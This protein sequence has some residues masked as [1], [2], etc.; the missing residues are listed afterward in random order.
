MSNP[1]QKNPGAG[2]TV[3]T[4]ASGIPVADKQ[5]SVTAGP[6][7]P[8]LLQDFHLI[9]LDRLASNIAAA[10]KDVGDDIKNVQI[11]HF[12]KTDPAYG[13]AVARKLAALGA[14]DAEKARPLS[15][16]KES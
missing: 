2:A 1:P 7:G 6:R 9:A 8:I 3:L 13:A 4:T 5:N 16:V 14:A 15:V 11:G 10:M 12:A